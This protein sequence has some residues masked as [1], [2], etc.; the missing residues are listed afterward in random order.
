MHD[1]L[2]RIWGDFRDDDEVDV[3]ILSGAGDAFS[4]GA[5]R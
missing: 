3:A 1:A 5:D 4:A 2:C